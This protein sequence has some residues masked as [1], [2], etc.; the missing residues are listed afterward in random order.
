MKIKQIKRLFLTFQSRLVNSNCKLIT[1]LLGEFCFLCVVIGLY[2]CYEQS[3]ASCKEH[4]HVRY[5]V[6]PRER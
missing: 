6:A 5:E 1:I 4:L 2:C 3:I